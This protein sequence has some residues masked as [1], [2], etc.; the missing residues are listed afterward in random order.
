M[1]ENPWLSPALVTAMTKLARLFVLIAA[2]SIVR[3]LAATQ[4]EPAGIAFEAVGLV[5]A[6]PLLWAGRDLRRAVSRSNSV[7]AFEQG[8]Q[9]VMIGVCFRI[10]LIVAFLGFYLYAL[11][12]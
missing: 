5:F 6:L 9:T 11:F 4:G 8:L 7:A 2:L 3:M 12:S 10:A 1:N